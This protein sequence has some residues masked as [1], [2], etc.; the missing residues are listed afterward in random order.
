MAYYGFRGLQDRSEYHRARA[1][2]WAL[3]GGNS[4]SAETL[5]SKRMALNAIQTRDAIGLVQGIAALD[6]LQQIAPN[7]RR[8]R[9]FCEAWLEFLRGRPEQGAALYKPHVESH[10][11]NLFHTWRYD[12]ACYAAM[13]NAA[14]CYEQAKAVCTD[15]LRDQPDLSALKDLRYFSLQQLAMAEAGLGRLDEAVRLMEIHLASSRAADN[16]LL[17]GE[18][19]RD[20]AQIAILANDPAAFEEH[21]AGMSSCFRA[22]N[23][24]SLIQQCDKLAA[25]ALACGLRQAFSSFAELPSEIGTTTALVEI[26]GVRGPAITTEVVFDSAQ[27]TPG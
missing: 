9:V 19:H 14:G 7:L 22:T 10:E 3:R 17:L 24:P 27:R 8:Y 13:L 20:R 6:R 1:E 21:F 23:T 12:V 25:Q 5:I 4:W 16:P 2:Q 11:A 18:A 26:S 15:M